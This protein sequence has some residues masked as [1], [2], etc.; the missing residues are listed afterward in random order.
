[1]PVPRGPSTAAIEVQVPADAELFIEGVKMKTVGAIRR[2]TTPL[3]QA[4]PTY[5]FEIRAAWTENGRE[6]SQT[7]HLEIRAGDR[8]AIMF[9]DKSEVAQQPGPAK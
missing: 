7:Q 1:M 8:K 5:R 4:G 3:L 2:F 6:V 9:L